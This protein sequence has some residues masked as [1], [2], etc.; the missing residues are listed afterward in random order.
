[1]L[2][3]LLTASLI[4]GPLVFDDLTADLNDVLFQLADSEGARR[5]DFARELRDAARTDELGLRVPRLV[6]DPID[7]R[8]DRRLAFIAHD[9]TRRIGL[10]EVRVWTPKRVPDRIIELSRLCIR[11]CHA[12]SRC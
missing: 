8:E 9:A 10:C 12:A 5:W 2:V 3:L 4:A 6:V 11:K 7:G 1:M